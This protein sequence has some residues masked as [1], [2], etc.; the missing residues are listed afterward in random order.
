MN[1]NMIK[2]PFCNGTGK[3]SEKEIEISR[4]F[5]YKYSKNDESANCYTCNGTGKVHPKELEQYR[6]GFVNARTHYVITGTRK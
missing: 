1:N 4:Y 2:C 5:K 6:V 3:K